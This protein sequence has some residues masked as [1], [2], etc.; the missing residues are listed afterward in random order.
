M[1]QISLPSYQERVLYCGSNGSGKTVLATN[2]LQHYERYVVIDVKGDVKI[3]GVVIKKPKDIRWR[4]AKRIV[5][6]PDAKY[7]NKSDYYTVLYNLYQR[8]KR[9][10]KRRPFIVYIDEALFLT[11]QGCA[12]PLASLAVATRS[13]GMGFWCASQ[14]PRNIPVEIRTEAWRW[15]IFYL[16]DIQDEQE[17]ERYTKGRIKAKDLEQGTMSYSFYEI[18]RGEDSMGRLDVAHYPP[19]ALETV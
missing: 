8:A 16:S 13:M 14:R 9:R 1:P 11:M 18:R 6:R 5:Y 15:Y 10:G 2:M 17:I 19:L 12:R 4:L 7:M 3:P